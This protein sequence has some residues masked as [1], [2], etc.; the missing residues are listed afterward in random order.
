[1]CQPS[2]ISLLYMYISQ[3]KNIIYILYLYVTK[4]GITKMTIE[5]KKTFD[6]GSI[7]THS[8]S[9]AK[10]SLYLLPQ[11]EKKYLDKSVKSLVILAVLARG[12][13]SRS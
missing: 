1:M 5:R 2:V 13:G 9:I 8:S 4:Q 11:R 6:I 10:A 12:G 7:P 3:T